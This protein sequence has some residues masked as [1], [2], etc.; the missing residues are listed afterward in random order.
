MTETTMTSVFRKRSITP[1][2]KRT[3]LLSRVGETIPKADFC[4]RHSSIHIGGT[5]QPHFTSGTRVQ[6]TEKIHEQL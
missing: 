2:A 4:S 1:V 5:K 3:D 6:R